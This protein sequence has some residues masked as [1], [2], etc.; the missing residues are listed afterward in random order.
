MWVNNKINTSNQNNY[1]LRGDLRRQ[2][3][4]CGCEKRISIKKII[5]KASCLIVS[6]TKKTTQKT[7]ECWLIISL[8]LALLA[9]SYIHIK[10]T[11]FYKLLAFLWKHEERSSPGDGD[12]FV[13]RKVRPQ[14][15]SLF[16]ILLF[17]FLSLKLSIFIY[18]F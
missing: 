3:T 1:F 5:F 17:L 7:S 6:I 15:S 16:N 9:K 11:Y 14:T 18:L 4:L 2:I 8:E 10:D 12:D 13:N